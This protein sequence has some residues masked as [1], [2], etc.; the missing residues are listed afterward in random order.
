MKAKVKMR[1]KSSSPGVS[2]V[3]VV[4]MSSVIL[5][6]AFGVSGILVKQAKVLR[7]VGN[8]VVAFFAADTGIEEFLLTKPLKG[9]TETELSNLA[10]FRVDVTDGG[11]GGCPASLNFCVK[12]IGTFEEAKRAI[13]IVY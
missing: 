2:L 12:S 10:K 6:I 7:G 8:S 1:I 13:E 9:I 5:S 3:F 11:E 4:L